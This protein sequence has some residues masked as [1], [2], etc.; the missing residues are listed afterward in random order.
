MTNWKA[1]VLTLPELGQLDFP[2]WRGAY[3]R[4]F[5]ELEELRLGY[6]DGLG[7]D[8]DSDR[9]INANVA[10]VDH[11]ISDLRTLPY[12][13]DYSFTVGANHYDLKVA[14]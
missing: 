7:A 8:D 14:A 6:V 1:C 2:N 4:L 9:H 5:A 12:G 11:A 3:A 13:A 10:L